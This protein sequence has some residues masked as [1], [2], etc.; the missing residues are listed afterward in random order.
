[1]LNSLQNICFSTIA[2]NANK[3]EFCAGMLPNSH[4][5]ISNPYLTKERCE[6]DIRDS[7]R[8][9]IRSHLR[10]DTFL[11]MKDFVASLRK[12]GYSQQF[13][14]ATAAPDWSMFYLHLVFHSDSHEKMKF[15]RRAESMVRHL[16]G[17]AAI[18]LLCA[19][20]VAFS[21][22]SAKVPIAS[23]RGILN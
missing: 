21:Q 3:T 13:V 11:S 7:I 20:R 16:Y 8:A 6:K 17:F 1:M 5:V 22:L 19:R 4:S 15:L 23:P 9:G 12:L 14:A 18:F 2:S 10:P